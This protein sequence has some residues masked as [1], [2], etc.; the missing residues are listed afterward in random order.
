MFVSIRKYKGKQI[1]E[2]T[3]RVNEGFVPLIEKKPGFVAYYCLESSGDTWTSISIFEDRRQSEDSNKF[4]A[5]WAQKNV[6]EF[7]QSGPEILAGELVVHK[8]S[9]MAE[10][11]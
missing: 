4:A 2:V 10:M 1:K 9:D 8:V 7:V 11:T 3:R 6:A 5:E